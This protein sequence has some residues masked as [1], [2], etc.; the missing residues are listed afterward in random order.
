MSGGKIGIFIATHDSSPSDCTLP[1]NSA[2]ASVLI[3]K[4]RPKIETVLLVTG[5]K[6]S[7]DESEKIV[8]P[9]VIVSRKY[10]LPTPESF[11]VQE[12]KRNPQAATRKIL[13]PLRKVRDLYMVKVNSSGQSIVVSR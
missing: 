8:I 11:S 12:E 1:K 3:A 5:R 2:D 6:L 4:V 7:A 10:A 9:L 13:L